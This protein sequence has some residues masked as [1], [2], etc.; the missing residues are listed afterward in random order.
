VIQL[1]VTVVN[2]AV[3][4]IG[5]AFGGGVSELQRVISAYTLMFAALILSVGAPADRFGA[6]RIFTA[7]L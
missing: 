1:D 2:V 3:Q 4:W 7:G 5:D 6:R